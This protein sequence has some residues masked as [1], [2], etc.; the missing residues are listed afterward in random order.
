MRRNLR[1]GPH[2]LRRIFERPGGA[3][4]D[5]GGDALRMARGDVERDGRAHGNAANGEAL[6]AARIGKGEDVIGEGLDG[7]LRRIARLGAA[8][9][10]AFEREAAEA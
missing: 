8:L 10:A 6:N 3:R 5:E 1:Q 7:K 9:R 4:E 2:V